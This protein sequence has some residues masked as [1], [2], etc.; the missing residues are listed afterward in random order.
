MFSLRPLQARWFETYVPHEHTV[1]AT[2]ILA[3]TGVVELEIDPR[4]ADP[5]NTHKLRY[6]VKRGRDLIVRHLEDLPAGPDRPSALLGNP[7]HVANQALHRLRVWS[8]RLDYLKEQIAEKQ[9]EREDLRLLDEALR[10][11]RRDG[12]DLEGLFRETRFLC[13]CLFACPKTCRLEESEAVAAQTTLVVRGPRHDFPFMMGMPDQR[14]IIRHLVVEKGCEQVGIPAWLSGTPDERIH[15]LHVH[16][17]ALEREIARLER[18]PARVA[19]RPQRRHRPGQYRHPGLVSG[20]GGLLPRRPGTL[21]RHPAGPPPR[22][23]MACRR[24]SGRLA[25]RS[26]CASRTLRPRR[27][28]Q[29]P[30]CK[31][32]GPNPIGP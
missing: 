21:P 22:I 25:L 30:P 13:K 14:A 16:L 4:L 7:V 3:R 6:F 27:H 1:R 28:R 24:H 5:L 20:Q 32:G 8:A 17:T 15:R 12:V 10:A 26:W 11:L 23:W 18:P 31:V 29:S 9:A 2:E 19:H